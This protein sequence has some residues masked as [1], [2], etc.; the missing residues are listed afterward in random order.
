MTQKLPA[1]RLSELGPTRGLIVKLGFS[2][3]ALFQNEG[4]GT[5]TH[6]QLIKSQLLYRLSYALVPTKSG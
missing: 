5:R 4:G 3:N 2:G 1:A 6:D